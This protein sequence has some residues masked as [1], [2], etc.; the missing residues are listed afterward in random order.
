[1]LRLWLCANAQV[2]PK[3]P[4]TSTNDLISLGPIFH[5]CTMGEMMLFASKDREEKIKLLE[6]ATLPAT[7]LARQA[8]KQQPRGTMDTSTVGGRS[9]VTA[10]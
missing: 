10:I 1:M 2:H 9:S 6:E 4:L 5:I 7:L 8:Q 3:V